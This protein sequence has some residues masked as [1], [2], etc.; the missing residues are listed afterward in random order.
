MT[1]R[2]T[3]IVATLGPA[4]DTQEKIMQLIQAGM[5]VA[6]M[7][8]SHGTHEEQL[9]KFR[10]L[11]K[12]RE[13]LG[14]HV[15]IL[16]DTKGPEIRLGLFAGGKAELRR[17][18][19]FTLTGEDILGD[20]KRAKITYPDLYRDIRPGQCILLDDGN[21]E[22]Q[23]EKV[24]GGDICTRVVTGWVI[25]DRKGVN[26]P[27]V[28]LN[29]E[30]LS[31]ADR[32]DILFGLEHGMD[33]IA[34]SFTESADNVR[35]MRA[36]LRENGGADIPIIA[37]I[38]SERGLANAEEILR[39]SD[40]IMVARGDMG[41]E[42]PLYEVPVMQ[43]KL[44]AM[45]NRAGKTVITA[46]Q[47]LESMMNNP[48]P[49]RA[50]STDVANAI[51]DGTSAVMLSGETASGK[52]PVEAVKIMACIAKRTE[53]DINYAKRFF[54]SIKQTHSVTDAITHAA[55]TMSY[56]LKAAAIL[57]MTKSGKT[58]ELASKFR[59]EV[60]II[61]CATDGQV[62]RRLNLCWG[63]EPMGLPECDSADE[64]FS[65]AIAQAKAKGLVRAGDQ[66]IITAGVP[67]GIPGLT[68]MLKVA[69]VE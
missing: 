13:T 2:K 22:L 23:V 67:L 25:S 33:M 20:E 55:C 28:H 34:A 45:A 63:V 69:V 4:S 30:Y 37:K 46:T 19:L 54:E 9:G 26:T 14:R 39:E 66:I 61:G 35:E 24:E 40:G 68:N 18:G 42:I 62:L 56:D 58:A 59:P 17:G 53:E 51:Y 16:L 12:A 52:Y 49:T 3:K 38:E 44:I 50:E 48:R 31:Q 27:G 8:F 57:A 41:V 60:P 11:Q 32:E 21:I 15:A 47:M 65:M 7:N 64:M 5:D 36:F 29:R 10:A 43:K 1:L 6:R